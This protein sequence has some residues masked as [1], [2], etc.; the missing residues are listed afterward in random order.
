MSQIEELVQRVHQLERRLTIGKYAICALVGVALLTML[1]GVS[2]T[3]SHSPLSTTS[4]TIVNEKGNP[5]LEIGRGESGRAGIWLRKGLSGNLVLSQRADNT[6]HFYARHYDV[7]SAP[8]KHIGR[9]G[10]SDAGRAGVW[11]KAAG[12]YRRA[13]IQ[14]SSNSA[15]FWGADFTVED[16]NGNDLAVLGTSDSGRGGVW[17]ERRGKWHWALGS[18]AQSGNTGIVKSAKKIMQRLP[19]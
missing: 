3:R 10:A 17:L 18:Q 5:I 13:L 6:A 4:L 14:T 8:A 9:F 19:R 16:G 7:E 2:G 1:F 12:S 11:F 15:R